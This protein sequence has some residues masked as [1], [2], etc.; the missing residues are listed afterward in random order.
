L[1]QN[2]NVDA[3]PAL[4]RLRQEKEFKASLGYI[5]RPCFKKIAMTRYWWL[6]LIAYNS[7][8]LRG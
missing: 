5:E 8:S 1:L 6:T 2:I 4:G 3:I 7:S